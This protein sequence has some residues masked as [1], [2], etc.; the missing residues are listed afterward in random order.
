MA[1]P[2]CRVEGMEDPR[3]G[4]NVLMVS[5]GGRKGDGFWWREQMEGMGY[6][7]LPDI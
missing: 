2:A 4:Y 6:F 7:N 5:I 3:G 1:T